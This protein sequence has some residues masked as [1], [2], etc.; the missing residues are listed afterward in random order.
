M[1]PLLWQPASGI[2]MTNQVPE[3]T[4]EDPIHCLAISKNDSYALSASG[5]KVSLYNMM[6]YKVTVYL[7]C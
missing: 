4:L 5:G 6:N 1:P 2:V 3:T 7:D